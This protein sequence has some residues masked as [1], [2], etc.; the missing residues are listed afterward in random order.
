MFDDF[1]DLEGSGGDNIVHVWPVPYQGTV[2]FDTGTKDGPEAL[3]KA[4]YQ[5]EPYDPELD[6]DISDYC[7]FKTLPFQR[8]VVSGPG[9]LQQEMDFFL[10]KFDPCR[11]FILTL[12][13][14]HSIAFPLIRFYSRAYPDLTVLQVDAHADL[15]SDFQGSPYSHACVMSR[16]RDLGLKTASLGIRSM[17]R[18][19]AQIIK[20][21]PCRIMAMHPWNLPSPAQAAEAVKDFIGS[22]PV[23]LTFDADG[24]DPS[25]MPGTGTPEPG[26]LEY[27]WINDFWKHFWPG[28][29]LVGMDFCELAPR[30]GS[31]LSES[32]G[33]KCILRVLLSYF[34]TI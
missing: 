24:L 15:R 17:D 23:Y 16:V 30:P 31:V 13:G 2:S 22:G 25:I 18:D 5:I 6:A 3:F 20:N 14:E 8:P 32:V 29:R 12:G 28:P 7:S 10:E 1:L 4:S 9:Q 21:S 11:D 33:V 34:R 26:G 27:T 19:Q